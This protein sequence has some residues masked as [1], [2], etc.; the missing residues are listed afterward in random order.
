MQIIVISS[1]ISLFLSQQTSCLFKVYSNTFFFFC[2]FR[3]ILNLYQWFENT[4]FHEGQRN[5]LLPLKSMSYDELDIPSGDVST[6]DTRPLF[7]RCPITTPIIS[8]FGNGFATIRHIIARY[9]WDRKLFLVGLVMVLACDNVF[10]FVVG[11][12]WETDGPNE[13]SPQVY[14]SLIY[15]NMPQLY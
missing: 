3:L 5:L 6:S 7:C 2:A 10:L 4:W 14:L 15:S 11:A 8:A 9:I 13:L 1:S 12:E